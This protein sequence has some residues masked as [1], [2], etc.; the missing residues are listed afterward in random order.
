VILAG[1]VLAS[2]PER[3][4][5]GGRAGEGVIRIVVTAATGGELLPCD[6]SSGPVGGLARRSAFLD[7]LRRRDPEIILLDAGDFASPDPRFGRLR[8]AAMMEYFGREGYHA[9]AIGEG[10]LGAEALADARRETIRADTAGAGSGPPFLCAN[11]YRE[12]ADRMAR[13]GETHR[14]FTAGGTVVGVTAVID[15]ALVDSLEGA[16]GALIAEDPEHALRAVAA[17]FTEAGAAVRV[18]LAH[19][20]E[21]RALDLAR[22][23]GAFNVVVI[24]H[25]PSARYTHGVESGM[26]VV[27]PGDRGRW[28]A[29]IALRLDGSGVGEVAG[30]AHPLDEQM[31]LDVETYRWVAGV[32]DQIKVLVRESMLRK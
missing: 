23:S 6:C 19:M 22:R 10:D 31:P 24:G 7:T 32:E 9:V 15:P 20:T 18:L 8:S 3:S 5:G 27:R 12:E 16:A 26:V 17:A 14:L 30:R 11:L 21:P 4:D 1:I 28:I 25:E 2:S 13:I 29:E